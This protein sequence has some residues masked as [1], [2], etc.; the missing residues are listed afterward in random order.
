MSIPRLSV[1]RSSGAAA[2]PFLLATAR[3]SIWRIEIEADGDDVAVLLA[4]QQVARAAQFQIQR[5]DAETRPELAEFAQRRQPPPRQR[6][7]SHLR[8]APGDR[9]RRAG[10]S[11]PRAR[12][13][14]TAPKGQSDRRDS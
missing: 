2:S 13:A 12:E 9:R 7:Q 11:G 6:R 4:P 1:A 8:G 5:R 14:D 10:S 3:S